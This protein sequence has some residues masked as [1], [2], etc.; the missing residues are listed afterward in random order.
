RCDTVFTLDVVQRGQLVKAGATAA[1]VDALEKKR[2]ALSDVGNIAL[3][4]DC[5]GSMQD[6]TPELVTKM[7]AA[8]K[9]VTELIRKIPDGKH[10]CFIIYGHD[11]ALECQAVKVVRPP[12]EIDAEA[13]SDL[14]RVISGLQPIG[15]TPIALALRTAGEQL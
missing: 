2:R 15:H 14:T 3:I 1:L 13:K 11:A 6:K 9:V 5:S 7:E 8:K 10:V 12:G 4:L